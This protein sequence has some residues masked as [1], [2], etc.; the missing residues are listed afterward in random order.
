[1]SMRS[2]HHASLR[3][4]ALACAFAAASAAAPS[5][6]DDAAAKSAAPSKKTTVTVITAAQ[7]L[8]VVRDPLSGMLRAPTDEE[9]ASL[10]RTAP[11]AATTEPGPEQAKVHAPTGSR[12]L[13]LG[14]N[15]LSYVVVRRNADGSM[16]EVCVTGPDAAAK[17][18]MAPTSSTKELP[19][20]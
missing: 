20:E 8:T 9:R 3:P 7:A 2:K 12:G 18:V 17:A 1:M 16:T 5:W 15:T 10:T 11:A 4:I 6:A 19:R 14:E 13:K